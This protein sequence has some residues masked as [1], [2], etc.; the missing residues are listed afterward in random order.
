[1]SE[2]SRDERF[3]MA[4][5]AFGRRGLGHAAP[6][7][8]VG[9]LI[10]RDGVVIGRGVTAPG[11]RPHAERLAIEEAGKAARGAT[12]YVTLEPCAHQ[13][14]G[15]PCARAIVDAGLGR[16]VSAIED[17]DP[18][19][20]GHGHAALRD[21]GI[22]LLVGV[23]A[24]EA[25]RAHVGHRLRVAERRPAVTLKLAQ[26]ADGYAAGARYDPRLTIT[27]EAANGRVQMMRAMHE[28]IMVGIGTAQGDDPLL[29]VRYPGAAAKPLR[30]VLDAKL[31]LSPRSRL[32]ATARDF[33][34][35]AIA[36]DPIDARRA[37]PLEQAGVEIAAVETDDHG[38]LDL[39]AAL[40]LLATHG[41]TRVFSEGGPT[42]AA[43]L[44]GRGLA[45]DVAV[46]TAPKPLG[47]PGLPSLDAKSRAAL[48]DRTLYSTPLVSHFG[49]DE[50]K[51]YVRIF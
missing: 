35:L 32:A 47:R 34:T 1:V 6:N 5:L 39:L 36:V 20:A 15:E 11:G 28:A 49:L 8:S 51:G 29:T 7:P 23:G 45:D 41:V 27:G 24:E 18:R 31:Q 33:P 12:L 46:F 10:V 3:M 17:P 30:V 50:M 2:L 19:T 21:A 38:R 48:E 40:R 16:V 42:I 14:R 44:I 43:A 22:E 9:A 37:A 4:A 26:T 13:G 25:R